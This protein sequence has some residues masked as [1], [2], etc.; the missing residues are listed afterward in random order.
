MPTVEGQATQVVDSTTPIEPVLLDEPTLTILLEYNESDPSSI[1]IDKSTEYILNIESTEVISK[2]TKPI[3]VSMTNSQGLQLLIDLSK[4]LN[5]ENQ[6]IN[7][8]VTTVLYTSKAVV[9]SLP[10]GLVETSPAPQPSHDR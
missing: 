10:N 8:V 4:W 6:P 5:D 2:S 7:A 9:T 3:S 1:S